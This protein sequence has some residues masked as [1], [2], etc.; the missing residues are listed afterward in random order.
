[1]GA[2]RSMRT[3]S[4]F[5]ELTGRAWQVRW[6]DNV[7]TD[8]IAYRIDEEIR[9]RGGQVSED[10]KNVSIPYLV[11]DYHRVQKIA[12][13]YL[14]RAAD[15][16]PYKKNYFDKAWELSRRASLDLSLVEAMRPEENPF[17][18]D[19]GY[20]AQHDAIRMFRQRIFLVEECPKTYSLRKDLAEA[21]KAEDYE[22]AALLRDGIG[23]VLHR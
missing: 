16:G 12:Q 4:V 1:M 14:E 6:S 17:T 11:K 21:V 15:D 13:K 10:E 23:A 8:D 3:R 2:G 7:E 22:R 9:K 18:H 5:L 20:A 19:K